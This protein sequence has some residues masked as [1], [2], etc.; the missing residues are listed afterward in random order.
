MYDGCAMRF[1]FTALLMLFAAPLLH[2]QG[3]GGNDDNKPVTNTA[4]IHY[5]CAVDGTQT[6]SDS[7]SGQHYNDTAP[8]VK[9]ILPIE[10]A[11]ARGEWN[12]VERLAQLSI[13]AA[14]YCFTPYFNHAQYLMHQ[15]RLP[16]AKVALQAFLSKAEH[17]P[18]YE[19]YVM[20]A[21]SAMETLD[22]GRD[23]TGCTAPPK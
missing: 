11:R 9:Y 21:K 6:V 18:G 8:R 13:V 15:C 14:P 17:D 2:A 22:S 12:E 19:R 5:T 16:E 7:E 1:T 10:G 3:R 4:T 23:P 20:V